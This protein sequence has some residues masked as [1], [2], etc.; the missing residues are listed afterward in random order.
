MA[1]CLLQDSPLF[2]ISSSGIPPEAGK[3][4]EVDI[5]V[6]N[7]RRIFKTRVRLVGDE[8]ELL[9]YT[10]SP[11]GTPVIIGRLSPKRSEVGAAIEGAPVTLAKTTTET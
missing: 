7:G 1:R 6:V 5:M 9:F 4:T 3:P 2:H 8:L 11:R 10:K